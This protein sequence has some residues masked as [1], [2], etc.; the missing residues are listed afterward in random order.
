MTHRAP[1]RRNRFLKQTNTDKHVCG[2]VRCMR[3]RG[4]ASWG[5]GGGWRGS[6]SSC[7]SSTLLGEG[8]GSDGD[9]DECS[10]GVNSDDLN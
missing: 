5:G 8:G 1:D 6:C 7:W 10:Q 2:G 9:G 3:S 4:P